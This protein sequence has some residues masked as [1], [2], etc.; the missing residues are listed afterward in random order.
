MLTEKFI[1]CPY[2][3][4]EYLPS[5]IFIGSYVFKKPH[6]IHRNDSGKITDFLGESLDEKETYICDNCELKFYIDLNMDF[7]TSKDDK[8]SLFADE[9]V[10][11]I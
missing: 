3:G 7:N 1:T 9:Y 10:T 6:D 4:Y 2:C 5:E 8:Y 11:K